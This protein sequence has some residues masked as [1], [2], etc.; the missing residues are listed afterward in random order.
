MVNDD[1]IGKDKDKR[2]DQTMDRSIRTITMNLKLLRYDNDILKSVPSSTRGLH[3]LT[4]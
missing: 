3:T 4:L 1:P 2:I